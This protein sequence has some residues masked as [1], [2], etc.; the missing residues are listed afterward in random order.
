MVVLW[1]IIAAID[2]VLSRRD[3]QI[4]VRSNVFMMVSF[5]VE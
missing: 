3:A 2:A 5:V 4:A 1:D